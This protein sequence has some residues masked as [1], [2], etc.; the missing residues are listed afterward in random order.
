MAK[1]TFMFPILFNPGFDPGDDSETGPGSAQSGQQPYLC[2]YT[3]WCLMYGYDY[4]KG[5]EGPDF[6]D[7][8]YWFKSIMGGSYDQWTIWNDAASWDDP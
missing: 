4:G 8:R 6:D 1:K 3:D 7:Y 2:S 5:E